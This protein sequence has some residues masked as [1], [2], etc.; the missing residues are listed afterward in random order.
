MLYLI[1]QKLC[2]YTHAAAI[3]AIAGQLEQQSNVMHSLSRSVLANTT[4]CNNAVLMLAQRR[5][6]KTKLF[7]RVVFAGYVHV[8]WFRGR[9]L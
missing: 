4:R 6:I 3:I 2:R 1:S 5:Q 9:L 7:Q 8:L